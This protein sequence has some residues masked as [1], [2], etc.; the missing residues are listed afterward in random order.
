MGRLADF[1]VE[2]VEAIH[3]E[4]EILLGMTLSK[5]YSPPFTGITLHYLSH[6]KKNIIRVPLFPREGFRV[7]STICLLNSSPSPF[8][9]EEKERVVSNSTKSLSSQERDSG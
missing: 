4:Y 2:R 1:L 8:S 7:S 3:V 5:S 9:Y 6:I